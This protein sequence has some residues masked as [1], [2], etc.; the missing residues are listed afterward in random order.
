MESTD[1]F[2][3]LIVQQVRDGSVEDLRIIF[4]HHPNS[5]LAKFHENVVKNCERSDLEKLI[6]SAIDTTI[7]RFLQ[8]IDDG[9]LKISLHKFE[10]S[11]EQISGGE[12]SGWYLMQ[13]GWI[14]TFS[15][16]ATGDERMP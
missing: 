1:K 15:S 4:E 12:L 10:N 9:D 2:G 5:Q 8:L 13:D 11:Y 16:I 14:E 6:I 7:F 3:E